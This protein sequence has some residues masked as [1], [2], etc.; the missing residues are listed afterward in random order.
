MKSTF[1]EMTKLGC[2][3][4]GNV[5]DAVG[6][7]AKDGSV[8]IT[9]SNGSTFITDEETFMHIVK[10]MITDEV[11]GC[12]DEI[13]LEGHETAPEHLSTP[14]GCTFTVDDEDGL[15]SEPD[16]L[17][18]GDPA[19]PDYYR[20]NDMECI[21]AIEAMTEGLDGYEG[22]LVGSIVAYLWRYRH[23]GHPDIDLEKAA[24]YLDWLR[25]AVCDD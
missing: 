8:K 21:E 4:L 2:Y 18:W 15:E 19:S 13:P 5:H 22:Y 20:R 9:Y 12:M 11:K 24:T 3:Y 16:G 23:K 7:N 17:V 1:D 25:D 6:F 10:T 14:N